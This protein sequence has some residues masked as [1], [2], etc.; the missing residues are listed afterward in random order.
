MPITLYNSVYARGGGSSLPAQLGNSGKILSTDGTALSWIVIGGTNSGTNTGDQT[1]TLTGDVTGTGTGSFLATISEQ[2]VTLAKMA[3]MATASIIGRNTAGVGSPEILSAATTRTLLGVN[4]GGSGGHVQFNNGSGGFGG[5]SN[6]IFDNNT[7][8]LTIT[9]TFTSS[10]ISGTSVISGTNTGDQTITLTG[11]VTGSGTGSFA[12][13]IANWRRWRTWPRLPCWAGPL[14]G[15]A[16]RKCSA[17]PR[18][19]HCWR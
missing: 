14:L 18:P 17:P 10:N 4:P 3:N 6:F 8:N 12:A 7:G 2:S 1:I 15:L 16:R 9:G 11:D 5:S 19:Q 13:T